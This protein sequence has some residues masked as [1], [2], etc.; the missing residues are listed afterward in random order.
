MTNS[1]SHKAS[2]PTRT[3]ETQ[4]GPVPIIL[5]Q[6]AN[7]PDAI[8]A[9]PTAL[10]IAEPALDDRGKQKLKPNGRPRINKAPRGLRLHNISKSKPEQ[11]AS[12]DECKAAFDPNKA[13]GIGCLL[14]ASSRIVGI[15]IDD[16]DD[17]D[18][19]SPV[20]SLLQ[21]ARERKIYCERSPS[22]SGLRLFVKGALPQSGRR[23]GGIE[24][25]ADASFLTVTGAIEWPGG[26]DEGQWLIDALLRIIDGNAASS[27][28]DKTAN[29]SNVA[30]VINELTKTVSQAHPKLWA[31]KWDQ[32]TLDRE[33]GPLGDNLNKAYPSQSEADYALCGHIARAAVDAGLN[34]PQLT[35]AVI[36]V[37]TKSGLYRPEKETTLRNTTVPKIVTSV[38]SAENS[39]SPQPDDWDA[40]RELPPRLKAAPLLDIMLLPAALRNF[41]TD[42]A[43]RMRVPPEIVATPII[44][45]LGSVIGRKLAIQPWAFD[46][47][48]F[49]YPNLWGAVVMPPGMLKSPAMNEALK[50]IRELE[51][52]ARQKYDADFAQWKST[53]SIRKIVEKME[54]DRIRKSLKAGQTVAAI[55]STISL[56]QAVPVRHRMIIIDATPE[57]KLRVLAENPN[58][59]MLVLDELSGHL[60]QFGREGYQTA[61]A[62][63]LQFYDG[64]QNYA[65]DRVKRDGLIAHAPRMAMYGNLQPSVLEAL[66]VDR[67]KVASG[68][69]DGY[70]ERLLQLTVMPTIPKD[71]TIGTEPPDQQAEDALRAVFRAAH[72]LP[73]NSI[74]DEASATAPRIVLFEPDAEAEFRCIFEGLEKMLRQSP[75][76]S[77]KLAGHKG[78]FRGTLVK[79]ALILAFCEDTQMTAVPLVALQHAGKLLSFYLAHAKR[80]YALGEPSDVASAYELLERLQSGRV[81]DRFTPREIQMRK[82]PRLT[83]WDEIHG[84]IQVL[85]AHGYLREVED[86]ATGG[87]PSKAYLVNPAILRAPDVAAA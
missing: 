7:I 24:L 29:T 60:A 48:W 81:G 56:P 26:V 52:T 80:I 77:D 10:W 36:A 3:C 6:P 43:Q 74:G 17:L 59:V 46:P 28:P 33:A 2:W 50:F 75:K 54:Q 73:L 39:R 4:V 87:R 62:Q 83:S 34:G 32:Q 69:D 11:W 79:I 31:G 76:T 71:F 44:I 18:A 19:T 12:F 64:K 1:S 16:L 51:D 8:K 72:A 86:R 66:L 84:A 53:E 21:E 70:M 25:Y 5:P 41:I 63:E 23:R 9:M 78:K 27:G 38:G 30:M 82:W 37:F 40:P 58:G 57:A 61:R 45:S 68:H 47:T 55:A 15:D 13:F 42:V 49:E 85:C 20:R 35:D 22:G 67:A 14:Q 65:D